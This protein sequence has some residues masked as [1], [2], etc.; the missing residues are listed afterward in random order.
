MYI[1]NICWIPF[2]VIYIWL[3]EVPGG[4]ID[5]GFVPPK[6]I[7]AV[8]RSACFKPAMAS[9]PIDQRDILQEDAE[10]TIEIIYRD[11][12]SNSKTIFSRQITPSSRRG[13]H[14]LYILPLRAELPELFWKAGHY[15][16]SFSLVSVCI[17]SILCYWFSSLKIIIVLNPYFLDAGVKGR[18]EL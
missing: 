16:F 7:V 9:R 4:V 10:M 2:F 15:T 6:E 14:G 18:A 3:Q 11:D 17:F 1:G 13:F 5:A 12:K 8:I